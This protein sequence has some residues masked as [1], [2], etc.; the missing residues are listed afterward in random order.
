MCLAPSALSMTQRIGFSIVFSAVLSWGLLNAPGTWAQQGRGEKQLTDASRE[1]QQVPGPSP[2]TL[3]VSDAWVRVPP[4][5]AQM[6]ALYF[7]LSNIGKTPA[8]VVGV[9]VP[10][11]MSSELHET[12]IDSNGVA[13]MRMLSAL[14]IPPGQVVTL[15]PGGLHVMVAGLRRHLR[16]GEDI[17]FELLLDQQAPLKLKAKAKP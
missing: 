3:V 6:L 14:E 16:D 13:S 11:A 1:R 2:S 17:V 12:W 4:P 10:G 9:R 8:K 15:V 5:G 7:S